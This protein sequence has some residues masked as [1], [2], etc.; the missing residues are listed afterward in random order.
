MRL[1]IEEGWTKPET[2]HSQWTTAEKTRANYN[3][4]GMN[5]IFNGVSEDEFKRIS[6][7]KVAR[8]HGLL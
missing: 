4:K 8:I 5:V 3:R 7:A 2:H 1:T 6:T